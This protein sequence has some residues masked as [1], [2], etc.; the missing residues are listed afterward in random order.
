MALHQSLVDLGQQAPRCDRVA[1]ARGV[2]A[3]AQELLRNAVFH[4]ADEVELASWFSRLVVDVAHSPAVSTPAVITGAFATGDGLPTTTVRYLGQDEHLAELFDAVGLN[5]SSATDSLAARVDAGLAWDE[6]DEQALLAEA[7]KQRPPKLELIN[8]LPDRNSPV[9]VGRYLASPIAAIA[10]W[11][12]PAPRPTP[13][14][15]AI[16]GERGLL[17]PFEVDTLTL[18]WVTGLA[19]ELRSW[20]EHVNHT[21]SSLGDL[22]PIAR[23]AYG[24][25]CRSVA[26]T[27]ASLAAR[28]QS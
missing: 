14:R 15:L 5:H 11:S 24:S 13:D 1:T 9:N 7:L 19:L 25:A 16:G 6:H 4:D 21:E 23:T 2:L 20:V 12:A 10:R 22:P 8:G 18:A 28:Q 3:E 26:E 17:S 27:L